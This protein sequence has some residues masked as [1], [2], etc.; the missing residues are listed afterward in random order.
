GSYNITLKLFADV[1]QDGII[2]DDGDLNFN[3]LGEDIMVLASPI[4]HSLSIATPLEIGNPGGVTYEPYSSQD[5]VADRDLIALVTGPGLSNG[6][7]KI[8]A[9]PQGCIPLPAEFKSF[10]ANRKD[11]SNVSLKWETVQEINVSGFALERKTTGNWEEFAFVNSQAPDGN[12]QSLLTYT[13]NDFNSNKGITQYRIKQVDQ[14]ARFK[15]SL[16]RAVRG[17]G[18]SGKVVVYPNPTSDGR[19][20]VVF[21]DASVTRDVSLFD[22]TGRAIKQWKG[23]NNNNIQIENLHPGVYSL[24]IVVPETGALSVEKI[25]VNKR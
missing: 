11:K 13:F 22:M 4:T 2:D 3:E 8:I 14:D 6:I 23:V 25:V 1:D 16:I 24:R 10:T 21:E 17:D 9:E 5:N 12:S 7:S 19:V 18:Q 20:T 15:Y